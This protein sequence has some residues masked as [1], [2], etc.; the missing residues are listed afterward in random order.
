M[1]IKSRARIAA[2]SFI[3]AM[4]LSE[5]SVS[6]GLTTCTS[7]GWGCTSSCSCCSCAVVR[8]VDLSEQEVH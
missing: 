6:P 3:E 2:T 5:M 4:L 1:I 8:P 7:T